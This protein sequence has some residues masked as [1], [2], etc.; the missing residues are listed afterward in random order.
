MRKMVYQQYASKSQWKVNQNKQCT[1]PMTYN[2]SKRQM[3]MKLKI[4]R[5]REQFRS[6][7]RDFLH[8]KAED[9]SLLRCE[10][11][12]WQTKW[13]NYPQEDSKI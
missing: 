9:A 10:L 5:A 13:K 6:Y 1:C 2:C 4:R 3:T 8:T 11:V 7:V 12:A